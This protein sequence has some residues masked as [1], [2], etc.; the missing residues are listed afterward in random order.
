MHRSGP[1]SASTPL[2]A[3]APSTP[4]SPLVIA[5]LALTQ[6]RFHPTLDRTEGVLSLCCIFLRLLRY[7]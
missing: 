3:A 2:S 5:L 6:A 7:L 1:V 4:F